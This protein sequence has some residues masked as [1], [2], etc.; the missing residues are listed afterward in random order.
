MASIPV[1]YATPVIVEVNGSKQVVIS[2]SLRVAGY[3]LENGKELWT[4]HGMSRA[5]HMTPTVGPDG[6]IYAAGWTSGGDDNDRFEVPTFD[7]ILRL[8]RNVNLGRSGRT[9][10]GVY[11]ETKHPAHFASIG[12][13]QE[14]PVLQALQRF[15]YAREGSPVFIQSFDPNNLRAL[16]D[17]T[18]LPLVQLLEDGL[19]EFKRIGEYADAIGIAKSLATAEVVAAAHSSRLAVH[20]WTFRAENEFL[21]ADLRVGLAPEAHGDLAAEIAR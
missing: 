1:G 3:D 17:M 12:L 13:A 10:L 20:V 18:P 6:T 5:V 16:R 8:V 7:E 4:V 9:L 14:S 21:P 2:G 15:D 19:G 11:P